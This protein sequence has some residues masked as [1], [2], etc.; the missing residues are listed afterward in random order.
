VITVG[1]G[2]AGAL[3]TVSLG[4]SRG[5]VR[6]PLGGGF[7]GC[8][9]VY[10]CECFKPPPNWTC[11]LQSKKGA[12]PRRVGAGGRAGRW[13]FLRT[14]C[15]GACTCVCRGGRLALVQAPRPQPRRRFGR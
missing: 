6:D 14:L 11:L 15:F 3:L 4:A 10:H 12:S 7:T 13:T 2:E 9:T 5:A 8:N 1:G